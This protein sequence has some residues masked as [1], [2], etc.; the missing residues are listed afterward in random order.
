MTFLPSIW[1]VVLVVWS[2]STSTWLPI[3]SAIAGAAPLYGTG[4][5]GTFKVLCS[6]R[7]HRCEAEP[8]PALAR[9]TLSFSL[10]MKAAS[11]L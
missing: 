3:R 8:I 11:S 6:S 7:P 5:I 10:L 1:P 4:V 9:L 2:H